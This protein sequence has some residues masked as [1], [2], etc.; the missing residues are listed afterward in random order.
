M[1]TRRLRRNIW[2]PRDVGGIKTA[3]LKSRKRISGM[4]G[5]EFQ[6]TQIENPS[7][8]EAHPILWSIW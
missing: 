2:L 1:S 6:R 3:T 5:K 4:V 8:S 7:Y